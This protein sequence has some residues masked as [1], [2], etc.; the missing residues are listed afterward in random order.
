MRILVSLIAGLIFGFGLV[1]SGMAN[2]AKVQNFLDIFGSWDPSLAF[3]MAGAIAVSM[4]GFVYAGKRNA[5]V[6]NSSFAWPTKKDLDKELLTGAGIFGI[7]W[8]MV[9]LCPGPAIVALGSSKTETLIFFAFM[10][11]GLVLVKTIRSSQT[12]IGATA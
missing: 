10:L 4:L 6:L 5:P 2:P 9:G 7:G 3:V 8:G 12:G 11:A 1:I